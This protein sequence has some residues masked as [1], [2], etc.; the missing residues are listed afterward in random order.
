MLRYTVSK[1]P[2]HGVSL[3]ERPVRVFHSAVLS[4]WSLGV[5]SGTLTETIVF[6]PLS[7]PRLAV[8]KVLMVILSERKRLACGMH[9]EG[10]ELPYVRTAIIAFTNWTVYFLHLRGF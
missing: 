5:F 4:L 3:L 9:R 8:S 1:I 6:H 7:C 2:D 10:K